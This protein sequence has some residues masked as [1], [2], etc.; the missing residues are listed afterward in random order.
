[1]YIEVNI[2]KALY[3]LVPL[4]LLARR[5]SLC[6]DHT[7]SLCCD[8][9]NVDEYELM[10][11]PATESY[12]PLV[13]IRFAPRHQCTL[14]LAQSCGQ[15]HNSGVH[16]IQVTCDSSC[17]SVLNST[18]LECW[19]EVITMVSYVIH[20]CKMMC[21]ALY[22]IVWPLP[23]WCWRVVK[24]W[25]R[26]VFRFAIYC[27]VK[28]VIIMNIFCFKDVVNSVFIMSAS[29]FNYI[30]NISCDALLFCPTFRKS[31]LLTPLPLFV[32]FVYYAYCAGRGGK[33]S[34]SSSFAW[35]FLLFGAM[36]FSFVSS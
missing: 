1:M 9:S 21:V 8:D 16:L 18:N 10:L 30:C 20:L 31:S 12:F 36:M 33:S 24:N 4:L 32:S 22:G 35:R 34:A 29:V 2:I 26:S 27:S 7:K 13:P 17:A 19:R 5:S 14:H 15:F 28:S 3:E 6:C 11:L 23:H 25:L